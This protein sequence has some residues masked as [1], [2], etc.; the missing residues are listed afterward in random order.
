MKPAPPPR[1]PEGTPFQKFDHLFRTLIAVPKSVV[2]REEAK[3][4]RRKK[5]AKKPR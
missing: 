2:N 4:K 5:R 1:L 3:L